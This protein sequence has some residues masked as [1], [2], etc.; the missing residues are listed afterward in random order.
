MKSNYRNSI[1]SK[2]VIQIS[3][4][5][6]AVLAILIVT[7]IFVTAI[8]PSPYILIAV[9]AAEQTMPSLVKTSNNNTSS[10]AAL[11][12]AVASN[13]NTFPT[14]GNPS[15]VYEEI[16]KSSAPSPVYINGTHAQATAFT[17]NG[18]LAG[19]PDTDTGT[20]YLVTRPDGS[21][22]TFGNGV[23]VS[24]MGNGILTYT[25]DARMV[26]YTTLAMSLLKVQQEILPLFLTR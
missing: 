1:L 23:I 15:V 8:F 10:S 9:A 26:S 3:D 11:A 13:N 5:A 6:T 21:V 22:Y 24:K 2:I 18:T 7:A 16:D 25:F 14:L 17:G 4:T 19:I 20:A 12:K